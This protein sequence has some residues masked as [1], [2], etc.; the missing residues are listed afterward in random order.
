MTKK[1]KLVF[2]FDGTLVDSMTQWANKMFYVL[3]KRNLP[4]PDDLI[5]TI[6]PLGD[7]GTAEYFIQHLGAKGS[8]QDLIADMD[9]YAMQEY[10]Y[11]IPAKVSVEETLIRLKERGYSLNVLTASPHRMLDVCLKRLRLFTLFDN[12]WSCEDFGMTKSNVQIY[13]QVAE[14]LQTSAE[15]CIFFDDNIHALMVAKQAG[16]Q[17]I[18]VY[19]DSAL[20]YREEIQ[21]TVSQYIYRFDEMIIE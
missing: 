5:K 19:D 8:V 11:R 3:R 4:Y 12:V 6:T 17:V 13:H 14:R 7:I 10:A 15:N 16:M 20:E 21:K 18:G 1:K 9:E 2:D